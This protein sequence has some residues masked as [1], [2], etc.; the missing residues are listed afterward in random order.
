VD[1]EQHDVIVEHPAGSN[2]RR[3]RDIW[4]TVFAGAL[5]TRQGVGA[6][7]P[8]FTE[9]ASVALGIRQF[10]QLGE[11]RHL[12]YLQAAIFVEPF[13]GSS[14]PITTDFPQRTP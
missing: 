11:L 10:F 5:Q 12:K 7:L 13:D 4:N 6:P 2:L 9:A 1:S 8:I 14:G 3:P